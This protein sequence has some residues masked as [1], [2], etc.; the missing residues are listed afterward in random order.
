VPR[1]VGP[2]GDQVSQ[3]D[4]ALALA[5]VERVLAE[6]S[7]LRELWADVDDDA[8]MEGVQAASFCADDRM[9]EGRGGQSVRV[10]RH[11]PGRGGRA[12]VASPEAI[13]RSTRSRYELWPVAVLYVVSQLRAASRAASLSSGAGGRGRACVTSSL[14]GIT[15]S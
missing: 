1:R 2:N 6:E 9:R 11:L 10:P 3:L 5:A 7:E 14:G 13:A 4:A 8:W 12:A 15:A